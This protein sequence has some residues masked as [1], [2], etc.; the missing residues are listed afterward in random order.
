MLFVPADADLSE[1]LLPSDIPID[2]DGFVLLGAPVGSTAFCSS[3]AYKRVEKIQS[4]L[5][6]LPELDD[7]QMEYVLLHSYSE[8]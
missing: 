7:S 2:R 6:L 1:N 8:S 4:A 3:Q 5:D